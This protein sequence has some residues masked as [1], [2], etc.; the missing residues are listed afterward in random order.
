MSAARELR[1][2]TAIPSREIRSTRAPTIESVTLIADFGLRETIGQLAAIGNVLPDVKDCPFDEGDGDS[3][4]W[5]RHD[6]VLLAEAAVNGGLATTR[7][8]PS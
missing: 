8:S 7:S 3:T 2:G 5:L 1:S 4:C 6:D